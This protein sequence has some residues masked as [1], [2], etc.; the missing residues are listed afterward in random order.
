MYEWM[1]CPSHPPPPHQPN[2]TPTTHTQHTQHTPHP[3]PALPQD[4]SLRKRVDERREEA[5]LR[6]E[7]AAQAAQAERERQWRIA[8]GQATAE[9]LAGPA[10]VP[11]QPM[12]RETWMTDLP[13]EKRAGVPGAMPSVS[14]RLMGLMQG[15]RRKGC[16]PNAA[17][18]ALVRLCALRS[19]LEVV[20]QG[21]AGWVKPKTCQ[22]FS[23]QALTR[24]LNSL[25]NIQVGR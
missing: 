10:A 14:W 20:W 13:P 21:G 15:G 3:P 12:T 1:Q 11:G 7:F 17:C 5:E 24:S 9:D 2:P 22:A 6:R 18:T 4:T 16:M 25:T 8:R 19:L 23:S